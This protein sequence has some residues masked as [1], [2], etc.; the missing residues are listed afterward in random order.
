MIRG[1]A[2]KTGP[3]LRFQWRIP[4]STEQQGVRRLTGVPIHLASQP[5]SQLF[6]DYHLATTKHKETPC[7]CSKNPEYS[8]I[9]RLVI[10]TVQSINAVISEHIHYFGNTE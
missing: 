10:S 9:N 1:Q 7:L 4:E 3:D 8:G 2:L 5:A 6:K